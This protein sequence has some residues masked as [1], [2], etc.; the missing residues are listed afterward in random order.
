MR[1][2]QF[3]IPTLKETPSDASV[4]SHKLMLKAGM[5]RQIASGLYTLMPLGLRV[6]QKISNIIRDEIN[7][8]GGS[9]VLFPIVQNNDVWVRSGREKGYCG[10]ETLRMKDRN[11][12]DM[13]FS[14]TAEE[15]AQLIFEMDIK[16]YKQIPV[17]FYQINTKFRDEIRPRFGLMRCREFIMMDCY[18][19]DVNEDLA[20]KTYDNYF[21]AY[22]EMFKKMGL[23]AVPMRAAS[24]EIGGDLSHEFHV[25]AETGES[26]IFY[27]KKLDEM[28][29]NIGNFN[30]DDLKNVYAKTDDEHS[31]ENCPIA[32]ENLVE[33]RGIEVGHIFYYG[34]KYSKQMD[35]KIQGQD[36]KLFHP[37]GGCY[38]IG[39]TRIM[40]AAIEANSD[41]KGI[42][43]HKSIAPFEV[44]LLNLSPKD[45]NCVKKCDEIYEKLKLQGIDILYDDSDNSAGFKFNNAD[46]IGIPTQIILGSKSLEQGEVEI[47]ERKTGDVK[48]VRIENINDVIRV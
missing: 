25:I 6:V 17:A 20:R 8:I 31:S 35:I 3:H 42:I 48:K 10:P 37:V 36:G 44:I 24:G 40:A 29:Q 4:I 28:R 27:D 12:V 18:S 33:K 16:S 7:K 32:K 21:C 15:S 39:V 46:L 41:E 5:I 14:P 19:F 26:G 9:E 30:I 43:W 23:V 22:L 34:D 47:K 45:E 38:G 11:G 1:I 13:L 2:T